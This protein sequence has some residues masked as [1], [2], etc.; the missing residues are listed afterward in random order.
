MKALVAL[1]LALLVFA[2][3]AQST[4]PVMRVSALEL[5][6]ERGVVRSRISVEPEGEVVLRLMDRAGTIRVKLGAGERGSGLLLLDEST[7]PGIHMIAR[8]GESRVTVNK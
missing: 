6:D 3:S 7:E 8:R 1:S 2:V 5:V 4:A